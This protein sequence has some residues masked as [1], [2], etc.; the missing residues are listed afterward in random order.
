MS[1]WLLAPVL[2]PAI[3]AVMLLLVARADLGVHRAAGLMSGFANVLVAVGLLVQALTGPRQ[4]YA[5]GGWPVPHG[6]VFVLD[7]L[8][9]M[10]VLLTS[11]LAVAALLYAVQGWDE[12]GKN[13]HALFQ[14]QIMGLHGAFLT[15]DLFNLFVFFEIMLIASYGLLLHG[16]GP[17]RLRAGVQYVVTNLVGSALFVTALALIYGGSGTLNMAK[18]AEIVHQTGGPNAVLGSAGLLLLVVFSVKAAAVPLHFWLPSTYAAAAAPIAALFAIMSKVGIYAILRT[19]VLV[20]GVDRPLLGVSLM[21][22]LQIAGAITLLIGAIGAVASVALRDLVAWLVIASVG[23]LL[24]ALGVGGVDAVAAALFYL[25]HSTLV[26]GGMFLL[27]E[28]IRKQRGATTDA[29]RPARAVTQPGLLGGLFLLG[30]ATFAGLPPTSGFLGKTGVLTA[31][32]ATG[33]HVAPLFAVVL[34]GSLLSLIALSRAGS[35]LFWHVDEGDQAGLPSRASTAGE[36]TPIVLLFGLTVLM[37]AFA[38][39]LFA[40]TEQIAGQLVDG[41]GYIDAVLTTT[42]H[43]SAP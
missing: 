8:S 3:T 30:A 6:I 23:T 37:S 28:V 15:G 38:G 14:F 26:T 7:G 21:L 33:V 9:A 5:F 39:P 40:I 11:T 43:R 18:V 4:V 41:T 20:F 22:V 19:H 34:G 13:F 36:L 24:V 17:Q 27:A 10:M 29:L 1:H 12:R 35:V 32:A 42:T 2:I 16:G 25:V 31:T